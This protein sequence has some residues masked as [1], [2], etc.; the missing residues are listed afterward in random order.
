MNVL[1]K[2]GAVL[3]ATALSGG[4]QTTPPGKGEPALL[5][6]PS[7]EVTQELNRVVSQALNGV[8]V[9]IAP[10]ALTTSPTLIIERATP[11]TMNGDLIMGRRMDKPDHFTL[12]RSQGRCVLTHEQTNTHYA[13][14]HVEC[15][16]VG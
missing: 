15:K 3:L 9:N 10:G 7:T 8:G 4:C 6:N 11:K 5:T 1:I 13:L 12:S 14:K 2:A 16:P